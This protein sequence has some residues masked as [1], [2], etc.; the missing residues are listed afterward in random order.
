MRFV[1][2][3]TRARNSKS[4]LTLAALQTLQFDLLQHEKR[5]EAAVTSRA[6]GEHIL[7]ALEAQRDEVNQAI[8]EVS[9][10]VDTEDAEIANLQEG[11]CI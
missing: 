6:H 7:Q 10:K 8:T 3:A 2:P 5:E 1:V 4:V 9:A 11:N